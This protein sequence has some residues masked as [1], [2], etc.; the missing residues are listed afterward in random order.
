MRPGPAATGLT[1]AGR[2]RTAPRRRLD[3]RP[4]KVATLKKR[5]REDS[6]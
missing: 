1:C 5:D 3:F 6:P 2:P 4:D